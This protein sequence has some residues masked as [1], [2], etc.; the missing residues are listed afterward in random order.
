MVIRSNLSALNAMR[1]NGLVGKAFADKT[2]KLSSG[3]Q[4][5]RAADDAAGL[6][7]SEKMRRQ[8]RGLTQASSN[9]EEGISF[10]QTAEGALNEVHDLLQRGNELCVKA[11]NDTNTKED[12]EYIQA[13]ID[14]IRAEIDRIAMDT[15]FNEMDVFDST[16]AGD[17][18]AIIETNPAS[19]ILICNLTDAEYDEIAAQA[20]ASMSWVDGSDLKKLAQDL[21]NTIVPQMLAG[22]EKVFA[23]AQPGVD[24]LEIGLT[25]EFQGNNGALAWCTTSGAGFEM[26]INLSYLE[27]ADDGSVKM[28]GQYAQTIIHELTHAVMGDYTTNG[29]MGTDGADGLPAWITEGMAQVVC[30]GLPHCA[31]GIGYAKNDEDAELKE[32][33]KDIAVDGYEAYAQ[34][35]LGCMYLGYLAG[36]AG[37]IDTTTIRA[38]VDKVLKDIA[39]GY[40]LSETIYRVTNG[41]YED[42]ADFENSFA[43]DAFAFSK[44]LLLIGENGGAGALATDALT[45]GNNELYNIAGTGDWFDLNIDQGGFI[46]NYAKYVAAG[47]NYLN[48]GGYTTTSGRGLDGSI[49]PNASKVWG[50]G[51][52]GGG[53]SASGG[54]GVV[55]FVQVGA[56]AGQH[57]EI[58][59]YKLSA[60]DLG[61]DNVKVNSQDNSDKGINSFKGALEKVSRIRSDYGATQ[62]RLEHTVKNLDNVVE[63]V[64]ASESRIRDTDMAKTMVGYSNDNIL[65]QAGQAMMAQANQS[66]QGVLALLG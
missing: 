3:Y 11:G 9:A 20:P 46:D 31:Y 21:K 51:S 49:N 43:D 23:S 36:G 1:Q 35:Y 57:I 56:E 33:L 5:N 38:G 41:K 52:S 10:I 37:A 62:N 13:E 64:T 30:G 44:E 12:R 55:S 40:S 24:D 8:I 22:I 18:N 6:S 66:N 15:S 32:W 42:A 2:E 45:D 58:S 27:E 19:G 53:L 4:I 48:G 47:V 28:T 17:R 63:N 54:G 65:L 25:L 59:R 61:V 7:I 26:T 60:K 16:N 29:M 14:Q 34:G 39:D 50:S